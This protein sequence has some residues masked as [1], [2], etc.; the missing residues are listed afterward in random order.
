[1]R[2]AVGLAETRLFQLDSLR[3]FVEEPTA[4]SEDDIDQMDS[5]G[6]DVIRR[7]ACKRGS[8]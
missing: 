5:D 2:R 7:S 8:P 4:S 3:E 6:F 1:M